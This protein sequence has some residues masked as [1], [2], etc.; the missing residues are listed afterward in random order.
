MVDIDFGSD[1]RDLGHVAFARAF[2]ENFDANE[3][4]IIRAKNMAVRWD[5]SRFNVVN[6]E[7]H[8]HMGATDENLVMA[9]QKGKRVNSSHFSDVGQLGGK[10]G[11]AGELIEDAIN[12]S[13]RT[14]GDTFFEFTK[15]EAASIGHEYLTDYEVEY[16]LVEESEPIRRASV[17]NVV[18]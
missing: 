3:D 5:A 4:G 14:P 13:K 1:R 15:M 16:Q 18:G 9:R 17:D 10:A 6:I 11:R 8:F 2:L 7:F 12:D